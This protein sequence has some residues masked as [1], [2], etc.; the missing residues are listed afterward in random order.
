MLGTPKIDATHATLQPGS[1]VHCKIK[2]RSTNNTKTRSVIEITLRRSNKRGGHY[3]VSLNM[4]RRLDSYQW[5]ELPITNAVIYCVDEMY[6][7]DEAPEMI[8]GYPNFEWGPGNPIK[9]DDKSEYEYSKWVKEKIPLE[10]EVD[11]PEPLE[12]RYAIQ[13]MG[14]DEYQK[15]DHNIISE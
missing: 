6:K 4:G 3:F 7:S 2:S 10:V 11:I 8:D 13:E 12:D 5:Q 9:Y 15:E 14:K 1:Y